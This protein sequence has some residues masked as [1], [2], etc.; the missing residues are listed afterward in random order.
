MPQ[1]TIGYSTL[2]ERAANIRFPSGD[3]AFSLFV[4]NPQQQTFVAP[5]GVEVVMVEGVGVARSRNQA[6]RSCQSELLIFGDDD[7]VF[8]SGELRRAIA[9]F[10]KDPKLVLLLLA[11]TDEQGKLR[12][13][14]P[15]EREKLNLFNCARAATYEIMLR[16]EAVRKLGV[17]FDESFGAGAKHYLGDEY[18]FISDLIK[19]GARCEF[20]PIYVASHSADSSGERWGSREDRMARAAVFDR[21]FG[22]VSWLV[23]IGFA[24][25]R[26]RQLGGLGKALA[27]VFGR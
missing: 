1:L 2:A 26:Y 10:E 18:I 27:F 9:E 12:K 7:V 13:R 6:L 17:S 15:R 8:H 19:K 20:A 11:A 22:P 14:Y 23:R 21:V 24:L 5:A 4:Q 3:F 16:P 25:R